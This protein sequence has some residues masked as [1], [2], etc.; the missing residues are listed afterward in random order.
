[1]RIQ[2]KETYKSKRG[3]GKQ[4][5]DGGN[6]KVTAD[7]DKPQGDAKQSADVGNQK[8]TADQHQLQGCDEEEENEGGR[9]E[10]VLFIT[11][12][13]GVLEILKKILKDKPGAIHETNTLDQNLLHVAVK[14][15]QPRVFEHLEKYLKKEELWES[16]VGRADKDGNTI[17]HLTA[18]LSQYK[19]WHIA[20]S[21]LQ[22][23]WEV[24]W[25]LFMETKM[26]Q[27]MQFLPNKSN[28]A[29]EDIFVS[30]HE[31]LLNQ[32]NE[33]LKITSESCS[34]VAALIAGVAFARATTFPGGTQ[35]ETGKPYLERHLAFNLFAFTSLL[36]LSCSITSLVMFLSIL[37]SRQQPRDFRKDLPLKLL[38]GLSCLFVSIASVLVSFS[39]AF[40]FLLREHLQQ[41]VFPL[42]AVTILPITFFGVAQFP[43]Y[44]DLVRAILFKSPQSSN[45]ESEKLIL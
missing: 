40:F 37:T 7:Q 36:A 33:W 43:L 17:L 9:N 38:L 23:Q 21:S 30:D 34:V 14:N 3:D 20:G 1:M 5:T 12:K 6:Q 8:V 22:M 26:P 19:P 2:D 27:H 44:I 11:A 32:D 13:N 15:R 41:V 39:S 28:N 16:H 4:S 24:K 29:P 31:K 25:F 42:Y 35:E 18:N 10:S 45:R